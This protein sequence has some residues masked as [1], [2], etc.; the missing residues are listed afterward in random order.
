MSQSANA[1]WTYVSMSPHE[2]SRAGN[3]SV[4]SVVLLVES[5]P[6]YSLYVHFWKPFIRSIHKAACRISHT[7]KVYTH[8]RRLACRRIQRAY[9]DR[10]YVPKETAAG[11]HVL[12]AFVIRSVV[13]LST[14]RIEEIDCSP[15]S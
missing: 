2:I 9:L 8:R 4:S 12:H 1:Q 3:A 10:L 13:S 15:T 7:L 14:C 11:V 5:F 6:A